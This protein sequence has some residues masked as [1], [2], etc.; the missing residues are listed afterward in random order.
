MKKTRIEISVI[1][2]ENGEEVSRKELFKPNEVFAVNFVKGIEEVPSES[3]YREYRLTG[4]DTLTT[5]FKGN[6]DTQTKSHN[7]FG[8]K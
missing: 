3:Q 6:E 7:L 2:I 8:V 5:Q 4:I 1:E